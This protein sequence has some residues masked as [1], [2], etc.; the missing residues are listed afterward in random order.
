[1]P[2]EEEEASSTDEDMMIADDLPVLIDTRAL[3]P[4]RATAHPTSPRR[5]PLQHHP[6]PSSPP[7]A[8]EAR[9]SGSDE[10]RVPRAE[11]SI[12]SISSSGSDDSGD[13]LALAPLLVARSR[14]FVSQRVVATSQD[15]Y[16]EVIDLT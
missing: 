14:A 6:F 8:K 2:Q 4:E 7:P 15:V 1:M 12:I 10:G 11:T 9:K 5:R 16:H 13:G 3:S